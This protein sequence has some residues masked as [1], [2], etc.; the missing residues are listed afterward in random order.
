MLSHFRHSQQQQHQA[1]RS[2]TRSS[3]LCRMSEEV[4]TSSSTT[5]S[6]HQ[7][8]HQLNSHHGSDSSDSGCALEEYTWVPHGLRPQQVN[9]ETSRFITFRAIY[10]SFKISL[11]RFLNFENSVQNRSKLTEHTVWFPQS[12]LQLNFGILKTHTV[13]KLQFYSLLIV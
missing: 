6:A 8:N 2:S 3:S 5:S 13:W 4:A 9:I 7:V 10:Y 1:C 12:F 11:L